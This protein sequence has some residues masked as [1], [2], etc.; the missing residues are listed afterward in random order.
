MATREHHAISA[1]IASRDPK[2]A[3][4]AM[5]TPVDSA[6]WALGQVRSSRGHL[7]DTGE[8][9]GTGRRRKDRLR[10]TLTSQ[11]SSRPSAKAASRRS[12]SRAPV[13]GV[14]DGYDLP[15]AVAG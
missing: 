8:R 2:Q 7:A 3:R 15:K 4:Q 11:G 12:L 10:R 6:I 14:R 5:R 1:A 9:R 13:T